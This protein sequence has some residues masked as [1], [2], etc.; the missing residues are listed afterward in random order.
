MHKIIL[1]LLL[2]I[3]VI[4]LLAQPPKHC[5]GP[6][7]LGPEMREQLKTIRKWKMLDELELSE[8]QTAKF[9]TVNTKFEK[10]NKDLSDEIEKLMQELDSIVFDEEGNKKNLN[11]SEKKLLQEK[12][13]RLNN[14]KKEKCE[15]H[16]EYAEEVLEILDPIQFYTFVTFE[17]R[18]QKQMR[19]L[20]KK[21]W[22]NRPGE[23]EIP[24]KR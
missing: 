8:E 12:S 18:F 6:P 7:D 2:N 11:K 23:S 3:F 22:H 9:L 24:Q 21:F 1:F 17:S 19:Q 13:I 5:E 14:L 10:E 16:S 4:G 20:L 15:L